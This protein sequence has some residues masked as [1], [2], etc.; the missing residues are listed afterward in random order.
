MGDSIDFLSTPETIKN[1]LYEYKILTEGLA[2]FAQKKQ[3]EGLGKYILYYNNP[4]ELDQSQILSNVRKDETKLIELKEVEEMNSAA[5]LLEG[6]SY[7]KFSTI[8]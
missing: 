1:K 6:H 8:L 7:R 3:F 2:L 4:Q 5:D